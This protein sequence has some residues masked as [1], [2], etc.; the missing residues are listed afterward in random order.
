MSLY[1]KSLKRGRPTWPAT[2]DGVISISAGQLGFLLEGIDWRDP[3]YTLRPELA[4]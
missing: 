3:Q 4:G 2:S 1:A